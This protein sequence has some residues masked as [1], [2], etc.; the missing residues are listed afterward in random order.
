MEC[1][2]VTHGRITM[3]YLCPSSQGDTWNF[4]DVDIIHCYN[5]G[6]TWNVGQG[7]TQ[8]FLDVDIIHSYN[9]GV[10]WNV[11]QGDTLNFSDADITHH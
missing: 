8:I 10:T 4:S 11:G 6:I 5:E 7:D 2:K 1:D 9:E 3:S